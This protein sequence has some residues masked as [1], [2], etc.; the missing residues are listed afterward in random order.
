MSIGK[1]LLIEGIIVGYSRRSLS[2][3]GSGN[4]KTVVGGVEMKKTFHILQ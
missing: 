4:R 2:G 1:Y 3:T